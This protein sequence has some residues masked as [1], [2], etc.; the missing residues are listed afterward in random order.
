V[1][2]FDWSRDGSRLAYHTPGPETRCCVR[3]QPA[4]GG[5]APSSLHLPG[6]LSLSAVAP[7]TAF[8]YFVQVPC[9]TNWTS[10]ASVQ[11]VDP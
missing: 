1:A 5:S 8:I 6:S 2:E 11:P 7:D 4:I 3:R 10:G 9:Q